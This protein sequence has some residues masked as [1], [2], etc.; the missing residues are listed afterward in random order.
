MD[1]TLTLL[2]V[3]LDPAKA[4]RDTW[5]KSRAW[6]PL[7]AVLGGTAVIYLLYFSTVDFGWFVDHTLNASPE[8]SDDQREMAR[9]VLNPTTMMVSTTLLTVIATPLLFAVFALYYLLASQVLGHKVPYGKWFAF[10]VWCSVPRLIVFPLML[11]QIASSQGRVAIEELSMVSF[12]YLFFRQ[13]NDHV[14]AGLA[15]AIDL[16][17]VWSAV[18]SVI[19]F[20]VWTGATW[21]TSVVVNAIPLAAFYGL[22]AI[23]IALS[24]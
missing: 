23:K 22:W 3:Y 15:N 11:Y 24:A 9:N 18:I 7:L 4:F 13:P 1:T 2:D 20:R 16:T 5:A 19:G 12:N 21:R 8:L 10:C 6:L 17:T 14:W